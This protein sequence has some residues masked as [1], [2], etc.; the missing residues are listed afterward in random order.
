MSRKAFAGATPQVLVLL[1]AAMFGLF[2][3][4]GILTASFR[5]EKRERAERH[6]AMALTLSQYGDYE[7]AIEHY[8]DALVNSRDNYEYRLGLAMALYYLERYNEA[9]LQ[10]V[11]LRAAD[12]T[13]GVV[14]RLLARIAE[15]NGRTD[16]A[17]N[18]YRTAIFGRW[19]QSPEENRLKARFELV[20]LLESQGK[21]LQAIG[22]LLD[23]LGSVPNDNQMKRR[24]GLLFL[25]VGSP[26]NAAGIFRELVSATPGDAVAHYGLARAEFEQGNYITAA[27][28]FERAK[29]LGANE[30]RLDDQLTLAR[31][32]VDL[33]PTTRRL[34]TRETYRRS[35]ELLQRSLAALEYCINPTPA[36]DSS[37]FVGPLPRDLDELLYISR[38]IT[39][40]KTRQ[41]ATEESIE[42]NISLAESLWTRRKERCSD[43]PVAD[44]PLSLVLERLG[45]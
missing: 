38:E 23:L 1:F 44:Q 34:S 15:I 3:F 9:E 29:R 40:G 21:K 5:A 37:Q 28:E 8:R 10:L 33:D 26:V 17:E 41:R 18:Y 13:R 14:N 7:H 11:E 31:A 19:V 45:E 35:R 22:E 24:I 2:V 12:P 20:S 39:T 4:A 42:S 27:S 25:D 30:P 6:A 16:D 36:L 43:I 32:V